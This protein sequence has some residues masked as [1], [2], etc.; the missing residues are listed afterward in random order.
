MTAPLLAIIGVTA[1]GVTLA[2]A[3]SVP[4]RFIRSRLRFSAY[5]LIA[6]LGV[7]LALTQPTE[8]TALLESVGRL[9]LVLAVINLCVALL[10][11]PWHEQRASE[12]FPA[13]AQDVAVVGLF[14]VV[15]TLLLRDQLFTTSAVGAVIVGFALQDTLGNFFAGLAIQVE[16]PFRVGQWIQ[17]AGREG[18]V[19]EI[20]WRATK[21]RTHAGQFLIVPNSQVAKEPI[22]NYSEPIIPT[23]LD[24]SV[25]VGYQFAPNLVKAA[26]ARALDQA[27]LALAAPAAD[28][29]L[30]DFGDSAVVYRVRF[31][32]GDYDTHEIARD[33]LRSAI[34][35]VFQREGIEIP[36]PMQVQMER[37]QRPARLPDAVAALA[38]RLASVDLLAAL[39][40]EER[41]T[42]AVECSEKLFAADEVIVRQDAAGSSMFIIISGR[43]RVLL[44]PS[45]REV[46]SIDAGGFFGEM[47]LLTGE[48]RSA[49][50]RAATDVNALEITA[51]R[52]RQLA[53]ARPALVEH[54]AEVVASRRERLDQ[55]RAADVAAGVARAAVHR[56]LF[57]RIQQFLRLT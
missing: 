51:D 21:L 11:N 22:L 45:G 24:V 47:S 27:P 42:L 30:E 37:E 10:V 40:A 56:S 54:V 28:V 16:K 7:E 1:L 57:A 38:E 43:V 35:Y 41:G 52:F 34:W 9:L 17:V 13:I 46:A 33:Q 8:Q 20:T 3:F 5:L 19:A 23:R 36:Y 48:A 4:S 6:F 55:A 2:F 14:T 15:A 32:I 44:E 18:Q 31:W 53:L 26:L 29:L 25:G 49:S 50:V 12:R 39:T